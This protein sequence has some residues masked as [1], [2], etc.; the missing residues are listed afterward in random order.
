[1]LEK[2]QSDLVSAQKY[3]DDFFTKV[4]HELR[5]PLITIKGISNLLLKNQSTEE[6]PMYYKSLSLSSNY[7]LE[8]VNDI[9]DISQ[10]EENKFEL[11]NKAFNLPEALMEIITVLENLAV[12]KNLHYEY[13][14]KNLPNMIVA[15]KK[16]LSQI[17]YNLMHNA[18]KYTNSGFVK[19][20]AKLHVSQIIIK[21]S[22]SGIG[23]QEQFIEKLYQ[24][25]TQE[26]R[27]SNP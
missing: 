2:A 25:F 3:K 14:I 18:I 5:T 6:L 22:D 16:R 23:I 11:E 17:L 9:L 12:E 4:S 20:T 21:V 15:D 26:G 10:I 8:I 19:I 13:D 27:E 7:L 1:M 24:N